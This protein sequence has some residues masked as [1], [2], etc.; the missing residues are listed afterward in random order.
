MQKLNI[1]DDK[2]KVLQSSEVRY[3]AGELE[4][5]QR[6]LRRRVDVARGIKTEVPKE[7]WEEYNQTRSEFIT[8]MITEKYLPLVRILAYKIY[9]RLPEEVDVEDL[10]SAGF[11][12]LLD[13]IESYEIERGVKFSTY[14]YHRINGEILDELR[15]MDWVPRRTRFLTAKLKKATERFKL[16]HGTS[17]T[18]DELTGLL[19]I[20]EEELKRI[21]KRQDTEPI[22]RMSYDAPLPNGKGRSRSYRDLIANTTSDGTRN[23][24]SE[25]QGSML[26]DFITKGLSRVERLILILY[27]YEGLTMKEIGETLRLS[28]SRI[29]QMHKG[30]LT[31]LRSQRGLEKRL[32]D[33]SH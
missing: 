15:A 2:P 1:E 29:S 18:N 19:G 3:P 31:Q 12:G 28:Q 24:S 7:V 17:P 22:Q 23:A 10:Q 14:A 4:A 25:T 16:E 33:E 30:I 27:Y 20:K 5:F 21:I 6:D 26:R 13:A 9:N 8:N 11:F 32:I